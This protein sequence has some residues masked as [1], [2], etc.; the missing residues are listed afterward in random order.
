VTH[1][2]LPTTLRL[3]QRGPVA[4][5]SIARPEKRNAIDSATL[6]GLDAFLSDPP[7]DVRCVVLHSDGDHFSAGLD[8]NEVGDRD[9]IEGLHYSQLWHRALQSMEFGQSR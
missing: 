6:H 9:A 7:A 4:L 8:L 5:L 2:E 3:E 1:N